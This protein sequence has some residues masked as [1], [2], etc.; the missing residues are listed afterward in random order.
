MNGI[1]RLLVPLVLAA[2]TPSALAGCDEE[3]EVP[4]PSSAGLDARAFFVRASLDVRGIR[5]TADELARLADDEEALPEMLD[6]LV[7]DARFGARAAEMYANAIRTRRDAHP[8]FRVDAFGLDASRESE[9]DHAIAE[10][11]VHLVEFVVATDRPLSEIVTANYTVVDPILLETWPLARVEPQPEGLPSGTVMAQYTDGRPPAGIIATNAFTWRFPTTIENAQRSRANAISRAL[12]C[13]DYLDRPIDFPMDVN[14][15]DSQS[16]RDAIRTNQACQAC[17]ATLDP[18]A[19]HLWGF[20]AKG[21]DVVTWSQYHPE[22]EGGWEETTGAAPGYF[23][24][25]T[26]G[27]AGALAEAIVEDGRFASC[28][29]RRAYEALFARKVELADQGQLAIHRDAFIAGGM[30]MRALVRSL[31][32]DPAYRGRAARSERGGDPQ[33]VTSKISSPEIL[34][35]SLLDLSG[36]A[37]TFDGRAATRVDRA[38]RALAGGGEQGA[39]TSPSAG[40]VIVHR[41]LAEA[42]ARAIIGGYAPGSRVGALLSSVDLDTAPGGADLARLVLEVRSRDVAADAEEVTDL[43]AVWDEVA[44][45]T[46]DPA[47]AWTAVLTA[48]FA[49]PDLATY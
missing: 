27:R 5:P 47:E 45:A 36:Y 37:M 22:Q 23:G 44:S 16:I 26:E 3:P 35:S 4:P 33:P 11:P 34:A 28:A 31:L 39:E 12:L 8:V 14:L 42:S 48:L 24:A 7:A 10:E 9:F 17:H 49:D 21:D 32:D 19:S 30:S 46:G 2:A 1:H 41:R 20:V 29:A 13:E 18:F 15:T 43:A 25:P 6:A 38:V 40:H